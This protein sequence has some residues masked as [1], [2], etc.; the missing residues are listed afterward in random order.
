MEP[1]LYTGNNPI[2]FTDPTG[3]EKTTP[4]I[5]VPS[6]LTQL[7]NGDLTVKSN[8]L[9][10]DYAGVMRRFM[11]TNSGDSFVK[12]FMK[13]G[14]SFL[15]NKA[16][17]DGKF[18]NYE[19]RISEHNI[20]DGDTEIAYLSA[21]ARFVYG[22]DDKTD[23]L[24][25]QLKINTDGR[26]LDTLLEIT[27]HELMLHGTKIQRIINYYEKHGK[28]KLIEALK[29]DEFGGNSEH[30]ALKNW[31]CTHPGVNNYENFMNEAINNDKNMKK[32]FER[33][34]KFYEEI[35]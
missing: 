28:E 30:K 7:K 19:L 17:Q 26:S 32:T 35:Y 23:E 10:S 18:S 20:K 33:E 2:M 31:D 6:L 25:F 27:G 24:F 21:Q 13:K 11:A 34:N 9:T 14:T 22:I 1:Y 29:R 4:E 12:N 8:T 16:S 5:I 3:M 15:G